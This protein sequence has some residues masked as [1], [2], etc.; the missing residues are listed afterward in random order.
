MTHEPSQVRPVIT[1][2]NF[3]D[4]KIW[5]WH[6]YNFV[7]RGTVNNSGENVILKSDIYI[8]NPFMLGI[9]K[10]VYLRP[11]CYRCKCK[12][13]VSH[14]DITL[15]DY[16][17]VRTLLPEFADDEGVSLVFVNT[18]K[19][20]SLLNGLD[21]EMKPANINGMELYNGGMNPV[22]HEGKCR[23]KFFKAYIGGKSFAES[24]AIAL[25]KPMYTVVITKLR[26][27]VRRIL[28]K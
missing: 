18:D 20:R 14:S 24:L 9:L 5:G 2:I 11:S 22:L 16:W 27:S 4:K 21:A 6:K 17:G 28:K 13:G 7:V 15:A 23:R 8:D 25:K 10:D 12:N 3:R 26:K 1:D 19:G